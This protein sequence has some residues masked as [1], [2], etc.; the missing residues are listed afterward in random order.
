MGLPKYNKALDFLTIKHSCKNST[1][2]HI[3]I[4]NLNKRLAYLKIIDFNSVFR[5]KRGARGQE[6]SL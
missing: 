4:K 5:K 6:N 2:I 1:P 3:S